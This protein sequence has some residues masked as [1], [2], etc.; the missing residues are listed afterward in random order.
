MLS[1]I[2][3]LNG[4]LTVES[5]LEP[6]VGYALQ[7]QT[8]MFTPVPG[9]PVFGD[10][11][12]GT[13]PY[14]GYGT[15]DCI[16]PDTGRFS[17]ADLL[18]AA[19]LNGDLNVNRVGAL[20]DS[21]PALDAA[22]GELAAASGV[23]FWDLPVEEI[24]DPDEGSAGWWMHRAWWVLMGQDDLGIAITHKTLHHKRPD[25]FPLIDQQTASLLGDEKWALIHT[26]LTSQAEAWAD[27]E[28]AFAEEID[29]SK[30]HVRLTRLRLHDILLWLKVTGNMKAARDQGRSLLPERS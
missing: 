18:I 24:T 20:L 4:D 15:Y 30:G 1:N 19:G 25:L 5:P 13:R 12:E 6:I 17:P 26:D 9:R 3:L 28:E 29:T 7:D 2:N 22:F 27:L 10:E 23:P 8:G 21:K 14:W 16:T 11:P